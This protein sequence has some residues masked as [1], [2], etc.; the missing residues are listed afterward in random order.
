[1]QGL[2]HRQGAREILALR[3]EAVLRLCVAVQE[4]PF[5]ACD[6]E[7]FG[8]RHSRHHDGRSL[9]HRIL[10]DVPF[11][12]GVGDGVVV[13]SDGRQEFC[14]AR[15]R[16]LCVGIVGGDVGE[17]GPELA[18]HGEMFFAAVA[19]AAAKG[20]LEGR[21]GLR[22]RAQPVPYLVR[23]EQRSAIAT[24]ALRPFGGAAPVERHACANG[25]LQCAGGFGTDQQA[26]ARFTRMERR[27]DFVDQF[28]RLVAAEF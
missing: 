18:H 8:F 28:L 3:D 21:I 4:D 26:G 22:R 10:C 17:A 9:V 6:A 23:R 14:A 24:V 27:R 11:E 5:L 15:L 19:E 1:M 20:M 2:L 7:P 25:S 13:R 16:E 12:I